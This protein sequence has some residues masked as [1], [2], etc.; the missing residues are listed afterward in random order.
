M[1]FKK[2]FEPMGPERAQGDGQKTK[3]S[4]DTDHG[5]NVAQTFLSVSPENHRQD[6]LCYFK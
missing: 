5:L 6:C 2:A 3:N 1:D 4:G